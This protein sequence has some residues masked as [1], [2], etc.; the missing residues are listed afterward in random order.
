[1]NEEKVNIINQSLS[2]NES[3][4]STTSTS[5]FY[6]GFST[7]PDVPVTMKFIVNFPALNTYP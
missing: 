1:M 2:N 4:I 5:F 3:I 7:I 6:H